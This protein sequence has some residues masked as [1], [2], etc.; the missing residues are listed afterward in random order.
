MTEG[1]SFDAVLPNLR[2]LLFPN[3]SKNNADYFCIKLSSVTNPPLLKR[4]IR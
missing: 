2:V 4:E 3:E 1:M